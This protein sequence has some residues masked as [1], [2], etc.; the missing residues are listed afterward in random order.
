VLYGSMLRGGRAL[1][2]RRPGVQLETK[3]KDP[4][5]CSR[6]P[7][8][9]WRNWPPWASFSRLLGRGG[10][11]VFRNPPISEG[12]KSSDLVGRLQ[13]REDL[14]IGRSAPSSDRCAGRTRNGS[15]TGK[16]EI[17]ATEAPP[18]GLSI[19]IR[20]GH[21]SEKPTSWSLS[22]NSPLLAKCGSPGGGLLRVS[23]CSNALL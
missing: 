2:R 18:P 6:R 9:V 4:I 7:C 1:E 17:G 15:R 5:G 12:W 16:A 20:E 23:T 11:L 10:L 19:L 13:R 14:G 22:E 3:E 21:F 8:A